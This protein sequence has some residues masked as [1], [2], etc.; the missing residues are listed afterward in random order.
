MAAYPCFLSMNRA[1]VLVP[2]PW[3]GLIVLCYPYKPTTMMTFDENVVT[4]LLTQN[5]NYTVILVKV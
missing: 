3:M 5:T 4:T 2:S 1:G